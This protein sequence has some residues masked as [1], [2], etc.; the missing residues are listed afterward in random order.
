MQLSLRSSIE[1][2]VLLNCVCICIGHLFVLKRLTTFILEFFHLRY[3]N[4]DRD[5]DV[6][7]D[8]LDAHGLSQQGALVD[9]PV[10]R[11]VWV[12][13]VDR[14]EVKKS[15]LE[16]SIREKPNQ[17]SVDELWDEHKFAHLHALVACRLQADPVYD[18]VHQELEN[19]VEKNGSHR[20][21]VDPNCPHEYVLLV[22]MADFRLVK[23]VIKVVVIV[24]AK[25]LVEPS[26][27]L[28]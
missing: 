26:A 28:F 10:L 8:R 6:G 11:E 21:H 24:R 1:V 12:R 23:D 15:V 17:A 7:H 2:N 9:I 16:V 5:V 14:Y 4:D 19:K 25:A 22:L 3:H 18:F 20:D 27:L 13:P